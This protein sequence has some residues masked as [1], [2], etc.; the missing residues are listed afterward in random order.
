MAVEASATTIR[1][2]VAKL[3]RAVEQLLAE[4]EVPIK[5]I[6]RIES[7]P[8]GPGKQWVTEIN[9]WLMRP[10]VMPALEAAAPSWVRQ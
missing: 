5:P 3:D 7:A 4:G 2:L 9:S 8:T 6:L 10:D 1:P